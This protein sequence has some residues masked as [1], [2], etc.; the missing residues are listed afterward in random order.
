MANLYRTKGERVKAQI[1]DFNAI[2]A[3]IAFLQELKVTFELKA[4]SEK[5][6][7]PRVYVSFESPL[8]EGSVTLNANP[9][10]IIVLKDNRLSVWQQDVFYR[11]YEA[12]Q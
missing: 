11:E 4:V 8:P 7:R 12:V 1:V 3:T 9:S 6:E 5:G 10:D 2:S